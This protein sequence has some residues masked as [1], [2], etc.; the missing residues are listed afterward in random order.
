MRR[1]TISAGTGP[2]WAWGLSRRGVPHSGYFY[3][4]ATFHRPFGEMAK[5]DVTWLDRYTGLTP[6]RMS[7]FLSGSYL[8][9]DLRYYF[10]ETGQGQ[11]AQGPGGADDVGAVWEVQEFMEVREAREVGE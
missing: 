1:P 5:A 11:S 6:Y 7:T 2:K 4:G 8:T 10:H 9:V 3:L